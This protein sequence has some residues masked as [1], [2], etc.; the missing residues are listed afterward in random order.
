[1]SR[2]SRSSR[3]R[4]AV[5]NQ[6]GKRFQCESCGTEVLCIKASEG[7]V[8]CCGKPMELMQPKVLPSAD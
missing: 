6:L 5:A 1:M 8:V 4:Q 7:S 2:C 3:G